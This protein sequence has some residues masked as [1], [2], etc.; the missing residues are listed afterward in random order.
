MASAA[1]LSL[2]TSGGTETAARSLLCTARMLLAKLAAVSLL[3]LLTVLLPSIL[4]PLLNGFNASLVPV[5]PL[6]GAALFSV[7][8]YLCINAYQ[9][10]YPS[11]NVTSK[12][13]P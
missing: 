4:D 2:H 11:D 10:A 7:K 8:L 3:L 12:V 6:G 13:T 5:G 9:P 1:S